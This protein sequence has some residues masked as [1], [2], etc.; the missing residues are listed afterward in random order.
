MTTKE[1]R[2]EIDMFKRRIQVQR[3]SIDMFKDRVDKAVAKELLLRNE[4]IVVNGVVLSFDIK[5]LG[6]GVCEVTLNKLGT[7]RFVK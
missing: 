5:N 3:N 4:S 7:T 6:L 2:N 1:I